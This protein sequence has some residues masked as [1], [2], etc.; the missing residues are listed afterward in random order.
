MTT[1]IYKI[2]PYLPF[3]KEGIMP[4]FGKEGVGEIFRI[5]LFNYETLNKKK[6]VMI[7]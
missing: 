5:L 6:P 4:L 1:L 7:I 2:P 3:P